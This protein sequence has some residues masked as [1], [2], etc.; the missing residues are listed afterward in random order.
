MSAAFIKVSCKDH[1]NISSKTLLTIARCSSSDNVLQNTRNFR[2]SFLGGE[3]R[4]TLAVT[5]HL[6]RLLESDH[7]Q[8]RTFDQGKFRRAQKVRGGSERL[9]LKSPPPRACWQHRRP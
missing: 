3:P 7:D 4:S 1:E 5:S 6:H 9:H 2:R 8:A